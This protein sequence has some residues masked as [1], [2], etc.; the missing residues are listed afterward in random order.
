MSGNQ[1]AIDP[2]HSR[3]GICGAGGPH[4]YHCSRNLQRA[5]HALYRGFPESTWIGFQW[6]AG[7]FAPLD[8]APS[9]LVHR[10]NEAD[11]YALHVLEIRGFSRTEE[12]LAGHLV[13]FIDRAFSSAWAGVTNTGLEYVRLE[14]NPRHAVVINPKEPV[15]V[16]E[17]MLD[18]RNVKGEI[19]LVFPLA[20]I[21]PLESKLA[22]TVVAVKK[23]DESPW[24]ENL[25]QHVEETPV[26]VIVELG[27]AEMTLRQL[28]ELGE[29]ELV[30]LD[31]E[32]GGPLDV[33]VEGTPKYIARP[34]I[35]H[36]NMAVEVLGVAT[37]KDE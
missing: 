19:K 24:R 10:R 27:R 30:R 25:F 6:N 20:A 33:I 7:G 9:G 14:S 15:V 3:G 13:K 29:G 31:R 8:D 18:W 4:S 16:L 34:V 37:N 23:E 26:E 5:G 11:E 22:S 28:L 36:G 32:P 35:H 1:T 12:R 17:A 2:C 21:R